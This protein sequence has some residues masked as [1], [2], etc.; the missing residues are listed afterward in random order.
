MSMD[1][2]EVQRRTVLQM[3][4][5]LAGAAQVGAAPALAAAN[6]LGADRQAR[7][8]RLPHRAI[9]RSSTGS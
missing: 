9:G 4:M 6:A 5:A 1:E 7:R 8:L 2:I 3:T